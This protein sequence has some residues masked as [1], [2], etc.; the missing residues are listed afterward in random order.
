MAYL[1]VNI[2][3]AV[4]LPQPHFL[5]RSVHELLWHIDCAVF[6]AKG[7]IGVEK[8]ATTAAVK[9]SS[10]SRTD[11]PILAFWLTYLSLVFGIIYAAL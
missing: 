6:G 2:S 10:Q 8:I 1:F 3:V 4:E 11:W 9:S 7:D 5:S